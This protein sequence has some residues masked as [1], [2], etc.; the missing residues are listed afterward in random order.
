MSRTVPHSQEAY[1]E[2]E[3]RDNARWQPV[4]PAVAGHRRKVRPECGWV[5]ILIPVART[6]LS[7]HI[8]LQAVRLRV[9]DRHCLV[10]RSIMVENDLTRLASQRWLARSV[11]QRDCGTPPIVV[12]VVVDL[13]IA[14][15][16]RGNPFV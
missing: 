9:L 3:E 16:G 6:K 14:A 2:E 10:T 4:L 13:L 1:E 5:G 7:D 12:E 8:G 11:N 15:G